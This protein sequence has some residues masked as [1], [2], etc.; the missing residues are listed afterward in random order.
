MLKIKAEK[1]IW[2]DIILKI[3]I[4]YSILISCLILDNKDEPSISCFA[5]SSTLS[6]LVN[7]RNELLHGTK[8]NR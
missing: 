2:V 6:L 4:G 3:K 5:N 7:Y 8:S 1:L